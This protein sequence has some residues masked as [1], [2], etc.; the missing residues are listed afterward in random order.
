MAF[1][2][3]VLPLLGVV[4][5]GGMAFFSTGAV[6]RSRWRRQ[7]GIRWD[8]RR[9]DAYVTYA[10][11]IKRNATAAAELLAGDGVLKTIKPVTRDAGLEELGAAEAARSAAFE[12]VSLLGDTLTIEAGSQLNR[13]V[14]RMQAMARGELP[15]G[16]NEWPDTFRAYRQARTEFYRAARNSMGVPP[17][18]IPT[19]SAWLEEADRS[20]GPDG[21]L[22]PL[23][24]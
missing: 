14:W 19:S 21:M 9:L 8:E 3:Q 10:A 15:V 18:V 7:Q 11:S 22:P 5:G 24:A 6:E 2:T 4:V 16:A 13:E 20:S 1:S 23:R 12:G 17:A